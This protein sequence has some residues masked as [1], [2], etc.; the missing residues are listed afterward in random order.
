VTNS[1]A[2]IKEY[3]KEYIKKSIKRLGFNADL[4]YLHMIDPGVW[5]YRVYACSQHSSQVPGPQFLEH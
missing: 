1:A 3:I 2:Y 5:R 4:Y